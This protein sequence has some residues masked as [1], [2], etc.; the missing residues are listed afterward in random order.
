MAIDRLNQ[1]SISSASQIPFYDPANGADRRA[2]V[3]QLA[4]VLQTL[5]TSLG[6]FVTQYAAP[7][8]TGFSVTVA[9]PTSGASVFLLLSQGGA[10]AAGTLV[11]PSGVDG[12]EV[13]IHSRQAVTTLTVTPASG[14][15][16]SGAP[17]TFSA[18]GF[19]RLRFD[20]VNRL[21]CRVG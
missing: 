11:L 4:T 8:A 21:W 14:D 19:A 3:A 5:L 6:G 9:P 12:Q 10:Y 15:T 17:T 20:G 1:S 18:A 13:L 2:S 7:V 16:V